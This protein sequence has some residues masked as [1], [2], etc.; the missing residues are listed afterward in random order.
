MTKAKA[1]NFRWKHGKANVKA[2][3]FMKQS[4]YDVGEVI[5]LMVEFS[6]QE[7]KKALK[8]KANKTKL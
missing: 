3:V 4:M 6:K 7:V 5:R 8:R 1:N 2:S